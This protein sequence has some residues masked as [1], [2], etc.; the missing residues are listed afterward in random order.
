MLSVPGPIDVCAM[1]PQTGNQGQGQRAVG[2]ANS[3]SDAGISQMPPPACRDKNKCNHCRRPT[4]PDDNDKPPSL[5]HLPLLTPT[6][7]PYHIQRSQVIASRKPLSR[8]EPSHLTL[9]HTQNKLVVTTR[10]HTDPP[11]PGEKK[12]VFVIIAWPS[13][14]LQSLS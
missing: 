4:N 13:Y 5:S 11:P 14:M 8:G 1:F 3:P 10:H 12:Y 2:P 6:P 7:I 9:V